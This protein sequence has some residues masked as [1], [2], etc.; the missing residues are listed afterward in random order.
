MKVIGSLIANNGTKIQW[1]TV[2]EGV[3]WEDLNPAT[4]R[5]MALATYKTPHGYLIL[6]KILHLNIL[7]FED[8]IKMSEDWENYDYF[9]TEAVMFKCHEVGKYCNN[10]WLG[11]KISAR[12]ANSGCPSW[13]A[14]RSS[15]D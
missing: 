1:E 15:Y 11:A 4:L 12:I 14:I 2:L 7:H 9:L 3:S 10:S 8:F 13:Y 6:R 5:S